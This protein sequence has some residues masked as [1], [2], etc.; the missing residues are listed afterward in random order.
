M[1]R[2]SVII[3]A[4]RAE[5][6]IGR[7]IDSVLAQTQPAYE[8]IVVDDGSPDGQNQVV[9]SYG[10]RVCLIKQSNALASRARNVGLER[11][12][13]DFV[14]FL[15]ADDYWEPAKLERQLA[16]FSDYP[17][18]CLCG[19][20]YYT[21]APGQTRVSPKIRNPIWYERVIKLNGERAFRLATM[22]WTGTIMVRRDHIGEERFVSG[23][24]PAEDRDL[25]VRLVLRGSVYLLSTPLATAVLEPNSQ[26]RSNVDRDCRKMLEVI[27]RHSPTLG[28]AGRL[29]WRSHTYY[30]W[31]AMEESTVRSTR[32]LLWSFASWP[33]PYLGLQGMRR[34]GRLKRTIVLLRRWLGLRPPQLESTSR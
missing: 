2:V 32:F 28:L 9:A 22:L 16:V 19:S 11:A 1:N 24:E 33:L 13:G 21:E 34:F 4:Y 17:Q 30:R 5:K 25:W 8:I 20:S 15:D 26:S 27:D 14:A 29:I 23:L 6:T 3:P 7:A 31:A 10:D 12:R 18:T